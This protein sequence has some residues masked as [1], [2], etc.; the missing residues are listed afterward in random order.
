MAR[1]C[2]QSPAGCQWGRP[3]RG[4][5]V[6]A[7]SGSC[8]HHRS[9]VAVNKTPNPGGESPQGFF[10]SRMSPAFFRYTLNVLQ[11]RATGAAPI[12]SARGPQ[13]RNQSCTQSLMRPLAVAARNRDGLGS[14]DRR[15]PHPDLGGLPVPLRQRRP[16]RTGAPA[17][18]ARVAVFTLISAASA[19]SFYG[20]LR[21]QRWRFASHLGAAWFALLG[22]AVC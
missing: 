10:A 21:V 18:R 13:P 17:A 2:A 3:R 16:L 22:L 11:A 12:K 4:R 6:L 7:A 19:A 5:R 20:E 14:L 8:A 9:A 15:G 1:F